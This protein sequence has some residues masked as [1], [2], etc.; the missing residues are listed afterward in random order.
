MLT[1]EDIKSIQELLNTTIDL[2]LKQFKDEIKEY[3]QS[4]LVTLIKNSVDE[5]NTEKMELMFRHFPTRDEVSLIMRKNTQVIL[6]E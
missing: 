6:V 5:S 1:K 3:F 2:K 4:E